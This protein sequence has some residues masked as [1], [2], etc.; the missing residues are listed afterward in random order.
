MRLQLRLSNN[1]GVVFTDF[2]QGAIIFFALNHFS[3]SL[4]KS[5]MRTLRANM[6]HGLHRI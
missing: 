1:R 4:L 2:R 3:D 6:L 5:F